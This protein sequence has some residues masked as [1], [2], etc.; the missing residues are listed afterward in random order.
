MIATIHIII[1]L[2]GMLA[3]LGGIV[4]IDHITIQ[5]GMVITLIMIHI[6]V[7]VR[8]ILIIMVIIGHIII[9]IIGVE[10]GMGIIMEIT[11]TDIIISIITVINAIGTDVEATKGI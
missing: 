3:S 6:G 2:A 7:I 4:I 10:I 8:G 9:I 1:I 5:V 11:T